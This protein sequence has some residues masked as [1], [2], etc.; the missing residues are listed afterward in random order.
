MVNARVKNAANQKYTPMDRE[1]Q[2][3]R[4]K[5]LQKSRELLPTNLTEQGDLLI[6]YVSKR[7]FI[8][9]EEDKFLNE[10]KEY[11][12][13]TP[14]E[15]IGILEEKDFLDKEYYEIL[16]QY[17]EM[18]KY[19]KEQNNEFV[20]KFLSYVDYQSLCCTNT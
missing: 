11:N 8:I 6:D 20:N 17:R 2:L 16:H 10:L 9:D 3:R 19:L 18:K 14:I 5:L 13:I 15:D 12:E 4:T 7:Q 1:R